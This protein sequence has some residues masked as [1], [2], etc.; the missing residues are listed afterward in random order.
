MKLTI[1]FPERRRPYSVPS[2]RAEALPFRVRLVSSAQDLDAAVEIRSSAFA[3]H[4]PEQGKALLQPEVD[5]RYKDVLLLIAE[6]KLDRR[7]LGSMRLQPNLNR[8]LR[9]ESVTKLPQP[10]EGRRLVE[11]MRLG[12]E[13][14]ISGNMVMAALAKASFEICHAAGMDYI[15]AVGRRTT[16]EIYRS[17]RFDDVLQGAKINVP[18]AGNLPHSIY[19]LPVFDAD[20]RWQSTQHRLYDFMAHTEHADIHIDYDRVFDAFGIG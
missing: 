4:L 15:V 20:R 17:M 5:D 14:G 18:H 16:S 13:N 2:Q 3:R 7:V 9:I 10:Y 6:R 12:V 11:F 1:P 19:C 8:P